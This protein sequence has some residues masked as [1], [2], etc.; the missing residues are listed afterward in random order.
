MVLATHEMHKMAFAAELTAINC[1]CCGGI[2]AISERYRQKMHEEGK[3]WTCPYCKASWG[4]SGNSDNQRLRKELEEAK[5]REQWA[6]DDAAWQ[7]NQ[8]ATV[9]KRL[10]AAKGQ[11]TKLRKRISAGVCPCCHRTFKQLAAHMTHKH[12]EYSATEGTD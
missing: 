1:G 2:Y 6:K 5:R 8:K 12:P 4:Y 9:E 3:C 10:S 11:A 7:K